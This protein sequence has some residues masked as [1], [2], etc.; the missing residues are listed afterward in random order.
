ML[1]ECCIVERLCLHVCSVGGGLH[2]VIDTS[3]LELLST[4]WCMKLQ[5]LSASQGRLEEC[6]L[7]LEF[8]LHDDQ[9]NY[10]RV[11]CTVMFG[12]SDMFV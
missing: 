1:K 3:P 5:E 4:S 9:G 11:I 12:T 2:F 8:N 7:L 10:E 6:V